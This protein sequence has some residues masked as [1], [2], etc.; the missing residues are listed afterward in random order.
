MA[1]HAEARRP[2]T[3]ADLYED[4]DLTPAQVRRIVAILGLAVPQRMQTDGSNA[5]AA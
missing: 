4:R 2:K 3:L 5:E 1:A